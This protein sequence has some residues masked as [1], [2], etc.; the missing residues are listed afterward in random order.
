MSGILIK[1]NKGND[2]ALK[3]IKDTIKPGDKM[4]INK[5][6]SKNYEAVPYLRKRRECVLARED[7]RKEYT[8]L[9]LSMDNNT[10]LD[11]SKYIIKL[12]TYYEDIN[13]TYVGTGNIIYV[14][15][16]KIFMLTCA[17]NI[18]FF[19][20]YYGKWF[21]ATEISFIYNDVKYTTNNKEC[22]VYN[23][24]ING[25]EPD[26]TNDFAI[27]Q[28]DNKGLNNINLI[29]YIVSDNIYKNMK[30]MKGYILGY[31]E[32]KGDNKLYGM[33]GDIEPKSNF[34]YYDIDTTGGQSGSIIWA[35]SDKSNQYSIIGVHAYGD[36]TRN[37][38]TKI[39]NKKLHWIRNTIKPESEMKEEPSFLNNIELYFNEYI[40]MKWNESEQ[41][42]Q[43][44]LFEIP[45][46]NNIFKNI[47]S[48]NVTVNASDQNWG[49]THHDYISLN[50][51]PANSNDKN[52]V[53]HYIDHNVYP[54]FHDYNKILTPEMDLNLFNLIK[55]SNMIQIKCHCAPYPGWEMKVKNAKII[56]LYD[57]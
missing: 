48:I 33:M 18:V 3:W 21:N 26:K 7:R 38:G 19:D 27:I 29:P 32:L 54:G 45:N 34:I 41:K 12:Y 6:K 30:T 52:Y 22:Y 51:K 14:N 20:Q 39:D 40:H 13:Q 49:N 53:L 11:I 47:K 43:K 10:K 37:C 46:T 42:R 24:F 50:F 5:L 9:I 56:V 44:I 35:K 55:Q 23:G 57:Q 25:D 4:K 31:P 2:E 36:T 15:N 17:H 16:N 8:K 1:K 28:F